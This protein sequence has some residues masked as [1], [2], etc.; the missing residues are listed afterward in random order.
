MTINTEINKIAK[1]T[2]TYIKHDRSTSVTAKFRG[3]QIVFSLRNRP[4]TPNYQAFKKIRNKPYPK[5]TGTANIEVA[6]EK[7]AELYAKIL[8]TPWTDAAKDVVI[9]E[10]KNWSSVQD[11]I[12]AFELACEGKKIITKKN[13]PLG[14]KSVSDYPA[15]VRLVLGFGNDPSIKGVPT[16]VTDALRK[17]PLSVLGEIVDGDKCKVFEVYRRKV[18]SD[19]NGSVLTCGPSYESKAATFNSNLSKAKALFSDNVVTVAY[20]KLTIPKKAIEVFRSTNKCGVDTNKCYQAPPTE[21]VTEVD[22]RVIA[23]RDGT[24]FSINN[25]STDD[26][27]NHIAKYFIARLSGLRKDEINHLSFDS[28]KIVDKV[29]RNALTNEITKVSVPVV[30]VRTTDPYKVGSFE[31]PAWEAKG[32]TR[33]DVQIPR[34]LHDWFKAEQK[35]RKAPKSERIFRG[36]HRW[37][38]ASLDKLHDEWWN[39]ELLYGL[40]A[41]D[42]FKK[43]L[44]ELRALFGSE[45]VT[46][47]GSMHAAQL[48]LGHQNISTT[49]KHYANLLVD[50]NFNLTIG[51]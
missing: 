5:S 12:D 7:G 46:N 27:W 31:Q 37:A 34:W 13:K 15:A 30:Q 44:H 49:E 25:A 32:K 17:I 36:Q 29:A 4:G 20:G 39:E 47:T 16:A 1:P 38:V 6:A 48:A 21:V 3:N 41:C 26:L 28:F 22:D 43:R 18:L 19:G 23:L 35:R 45:V 40:D 42:Y 9:K 14:D 33:R 10:R 24:D 8:N 50:F 2:F 11:C 51:A